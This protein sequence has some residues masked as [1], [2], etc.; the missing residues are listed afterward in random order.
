VTAGTSLAITQVVLL[1]HSEGLGSVDAAIL[2]QGI[3]QLATK[4]GLLLVDTSWI[5]IGRRMLLRVLV[6]RPGRVTIGECAALS[7]SIEDLMDRDLE[8]QDP[9]LLEVSSPG[10]G[11]RLESEIDWVRSVGRTVRVELESETVEGEL[12]GYD[13]GCL[14]LPDNRIIPVSMVVRAVEVLEA[15]GRAKDRK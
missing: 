6:D 15:Q 5:R 1:Y 8:M 13:G 12:L 9:Y 4:A 11:R 2:K 10:I 7:R 3:E 14:Q